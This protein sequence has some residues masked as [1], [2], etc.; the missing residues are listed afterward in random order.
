[1]TALTESHL[2]ALRGLVS[3]AVEGRPAG[4]DYG[5]RR[6]K[7]RI[8]KTMGVMAGAGADSSRASEKCPGIVAFM[9]NMGM[10]GSI[11]D[12]LSAQIRLATAAR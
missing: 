12:E 4:K 5:Q 9:K 8:G 2:Q 7:G 10:P 6:E 3:G 11:A 1:M